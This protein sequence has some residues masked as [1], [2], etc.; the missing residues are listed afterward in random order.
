MNI[1]KNIYT[2]RGLSQGSGILEAYTSL[3]LAIRDY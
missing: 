1:E 2:T 3:F